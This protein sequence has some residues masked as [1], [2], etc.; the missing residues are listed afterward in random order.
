MGKQFIATGQATVIA[1]KDSYTINQSVSEYIFTTQSNGTVSAAVSFSS[2]IKVTLGDLNITDF[3]VGAITKPSGFSSITVN[4]TNKTVTYSVA[5]GTTT[6][7]DNGLV[8]IPVI[9]AGVTYQMSFAW[10]KAK[11]GAT[12]SP[13]TDA[14]MLDWVQDW[15]SNKTTIGSNSVITPKVFAGVKNANGTITGTAIGRFSHRAFQPEY[16]ECFG[17]RYDRGC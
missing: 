11:A 1:Q 2:V 8:F 4:N 3:T 10:S 15:N 6:L 17:D 13:G 12:G 9:I 7:A 14:N 16:T 5:A